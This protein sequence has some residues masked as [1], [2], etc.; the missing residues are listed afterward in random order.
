LATLD[1][2][3]TKSIKV[4]SKSNKV[5]QSPT[6]SIKVIAEP[7][8][9]PLFQSA[10]EVMD[11]LASLLHPSLLARSDA[12]AVDSLDATAAAWQ[13]PPEVTGLPDECPWDCEVCGK[14]CAMNCGLRHS[15]TLHMCA[16][17]ILQRLP[18]QWGESDDE[19]ESRWQDTCV[20]I[21]E[22]G[23]RVVVAADQHT[24]PAW[25][26]DLAGG[27][28][29]YDK[30][31]V[32]LGD[33][34]ASQT[35]V[36]EVIVGARTSS[37]SHREEAATPRHSAAAGSEP[38]SPP[39]WQDDI[40]YSSTDHLCDCGACRDDRDYDGEGLPEWARDSPQW[41]RC[42]RVG[43]GGGDYGPPQAL[44]LRRPFCHTCNT[45]HPTMDALKEHV[46]ST[47]HKRRARQLASSRLPTAAAPRRS[48]G[49]K[50]AAPSGAAPSGANPSSPEESQ[51]F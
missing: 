48:Y 12:E 39:V 17:D 5:N 14:K 43:G 30:V 2:S 11:P 21:D 3:R 28:Y 26:P 45:W 27:E 33:C 31:M 34:G 38:E 32:V 40:G 1:Q 9:G 19:G 37:S 20:R 13:A 8:R 18:P 7:G 22:S 41:R 42:L 24:P 35:M 10:N 51:R 36:P 29:N 4:E 25:E 46:G 16:K 47:A 49:G 23:E 6:K 50:G 44:G 15:G